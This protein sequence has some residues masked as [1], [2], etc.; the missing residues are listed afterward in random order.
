MLG[1]VLAS[2]CAPLEMAYHV[3]VTAAHHHRRRLPREGYAPPSASEAEPGGARTSTTTATVAGAPPTASPP[4]YLEAHD[5]LETLGPNRFR[6][7]SRLGVEHELSLE[8]GDLVWTVHN[9]SAAPVLVPWREPYQP[10]VD[11]GPVWEQVGLSRFVELYPGDPFTGQPCTTPSMFTDEVEIPAGN[12][13]RF[14]LHATARTKV[15]LQNVFGD[16]ETKLENVRALLPRAA[17]PEEASALEVLAGEKLQVWLPVRGPEIA[18][19]LEVE[20]TI[21]K[22]EPG[23]PTEAASL[24]PRFAMSR[25][26][27]GGAASLSLIGGASTTALGAELA[28]TAEIVLGR[29]GPTS[30]E[31]GPVASLFLS[32]KGVGVF[33]GG[34]F[35][36]SIGGRPDGTGTFIRF[37]V[38]A[39]VGYFRGTTFRTR[40]GLAVPFRGFERVASYEIL[41]MWSTGG[42]A[43]PGGSAGFMLNF[44]FLFGV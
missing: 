18:E 39:E 1:A 38:T 14:E 30:Y 21:G 36:L 37:P 16:C 17:H 32:K 27:I 10:R 19:L 35:S 31:V 3:D 33:G 12:E 11:L 2:G 44:R 22:V 9:Q 28:G 43:G 25:V 15:G 20:L 42:W 4:P 6:F 13:H 23:P 26:F 40:F 29:L 41:G 5:R 24:A 7:T 8:S 34:R